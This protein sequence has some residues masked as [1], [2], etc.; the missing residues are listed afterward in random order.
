MHL[1]VGLTKTA[2]SR[3][4]TIRALPAA[5]SSMIG[6]EMTLAGGLLKGY[7][8]GCLGR[9]RTGYTKKKMLTAFEL[10]EILFASGKRGGA[11][12]EAK[13]REVPVTPIT[14]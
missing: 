11:A 10:L 2:K 9:K 7:P 13:C 1:I 12:R 5:M 3:Y 8:Y 6:D 14:S 4:L